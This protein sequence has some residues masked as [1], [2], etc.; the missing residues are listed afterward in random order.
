MKKRV[1]A[2]DLHQKVNWTPYEGWALKG[3]P[4]LTMRKGQVVC[5]DNDVTGNIGSA[6]FLPMSL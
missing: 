2:E 4:I 5:Q 1:R 6:E 3:W